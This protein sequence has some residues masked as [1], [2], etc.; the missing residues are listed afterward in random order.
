MAKP[1]FHIFVSSTYIDLIPY[2]QA[3]KKAIE[4]LKQQYVGMEH[5]GALDK[6]PVKASLEMVDE[7]VARYRYPEGPDTAQSEEADRIAAAQ[8]GAPPYVRYWVDL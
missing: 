2:R 6:E 4:D 5:I 3:A 1:L 8:P 7:F